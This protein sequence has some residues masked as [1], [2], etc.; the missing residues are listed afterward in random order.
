MIDDKKVNW[1]WVFIVELYKCL[2]YPVC[3]KEIISKVS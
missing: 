1:W 3:Q 2:T